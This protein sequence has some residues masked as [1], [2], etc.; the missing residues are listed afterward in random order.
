MD[1]FVK[2]NLPSLGVGDAGGPGSAAGVFDGIDLD[3]EWPGSEGNAGNIV[4]PEDKANFTLLAGGVPQA[5]RRA[6]A[7]RPDKHYELTAFLPAAPAK[8]A[9]GFE[10][11]KIFKYLD[12][13]TVQ[14]YDFH[15]TWETVTNHQSAHPAAARGA[16]RS[17]LQ[18]RPRGPRVDRTRARRARSSSSASRTTAR[19]GPASPAAA[20]ACSSRLP[21]LRP[22][23]G[24][25]QRGLQGA[26]HVAGQRIHGPPRP[27]RRPRVALRRHDVLDLRR[28]RAGAAEDRLG[29]PAAT[30]AA[31]W[32]GSSPATTPNA[33][34][35]RTINLGLSVH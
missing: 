13:A 35:T 6:T 4:R 24:A 2:G 28:S 18:P 21:A 29:P 19:A 14:G 31:S 22:G 25:R 9:A 30:S 7:R 1:V 5:A 16:G 8:I 32:S 33:T 11:K 12:F 15:G 23:R 20:T 17:R 3:W 10:G 34:L 26:G 27:P